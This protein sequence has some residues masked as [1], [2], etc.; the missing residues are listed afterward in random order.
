MCIGRRIAEQEVY[1]F[2][3][4]VLHRFSVHY[5]YKDIEIM[6]K[7]VFTSSEPLRFQFVERR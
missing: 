6:T 7:L 5:H 4:R 3:A 2:L 1:T